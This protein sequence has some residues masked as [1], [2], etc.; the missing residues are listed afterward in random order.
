[1]KTLVSFVFHEYNNRVENFFNNCIFQ[2]S[3]V[4]FLIICN[5][6]HIQLPP[7]PEYVKI[8]KRD[9]V[10]YDFAGWSEGILMND[11]YKNY[12]RFI[13]A[14]SSIVGPFLPPD[15]KGKWTDIYLNGLLTNNVKLFGS[16][17]NN[18]IFIN[19]DPSKINITTVNPMACSHVQSYIFSMDIET[20]EFLINKEIFSLNNTAETFNNAI[21]NKEVR[22]SRLI[23]ENGWN[24][25][26]THQL[27]K[28]VDFTFRTK[29]PFEYGIT[30]L[31]DIMYPQYANIFWKPN[32]LVFIKGNR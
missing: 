12:E 6:K 28:N 23:I 15:F 10:G 26:C 16:T 7:L 31:G 24:I 9:N 20:L 27:Y 25:G 8:I 11:L 17:I 29:F 32:E 19:V 1:M 3:D 13:F 2:N 21:L 5:N 30:F 14:N 4:D 22:M 18:M